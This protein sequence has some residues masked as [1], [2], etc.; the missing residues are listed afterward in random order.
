MSP[1]GGI[2][3]DPG[4]LDK[5][6]RIEQVVDRVDDGGGGYTITW[7]PLPATD[8]YEGGEH[9]WAGIEP[10]SGEERIRAMQQRSNA[11]HQVTIRYRPDVTALC[12]FV[13]EGNAYEIIEPPQQIPDMRDSHLRFRTRVEPIE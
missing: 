9:V 8:E 12:R 5:D 2:V 7:A 3:T 10:L 6:V 11:T 13:W 1:I 4:S